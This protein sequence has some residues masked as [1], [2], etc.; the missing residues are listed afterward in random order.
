MESQSTL[1]NVAQTD[2]Y[3]RLL[4]YAY[5][6]EGEL[7]QYRRYL[8]R[9]PEL[10]WNEK[11][12][13]A[14]LQNTL[15]NHNI[16]IN[17]T[18]ATYGFSSEIDSG[19]PSQ[20]VAYRADMDA[21]PITDHKLCDYSS[22][23]NGVGHMCGHDVHSTI[24]LGLALLLNRVK[25][26]VNGKYRI[27]WQPAEESSDSGAPKMMDDGVLYGVNT[28]LGI[29]V[30]PSTE[31]GFIRITSGADTAGVDTIEFKINADTTS[32]SARPHLGKDTIWIA[33]KM[34]NNLYQLIGRV[35]DPREASVLTICTFHGGEVSNVI[36]DYVH[37]GGT[38]RSTSTHAR[39]K[40]FKMYD[41]QAEA[42]ARLYDVDIEF[43]IKEGAPPVINHPTLVEKSRLWLKESI[44]EEY[45]IA[46]RQSMGA[47][48]FG[49]YTEHVPSL[50][51]RV[52]TRGGRD[53]SHPL[54]TSLFD[55]DERIIAPTVAR[56]AMLMIKHANK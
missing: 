8:H 55:V 10:S 26:E 29:H 40:L 19:K 34:L 47:E 13:S 39:D 53:T 21:L 31:S 15:R 12:T 32:H 46:G 16:E 36:P 24:A 33:N 25:D 51:L 43:N 23:N 11:N 27:F 1:K 37:F 38:L 45:V 56:L 48:D 22:D 50:F 41:A 2:L 5:E 4:K 30:D 6:M 17:K 49:Y 28:L 18:Y 9:N 35:T 20:L 44:G 7:I 52:G 3:K 54:H 14:Y 42:T